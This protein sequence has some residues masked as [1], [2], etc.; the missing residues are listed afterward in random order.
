MNCKTCKWWSVKEDDQYDE[1]IRP[2][3][4]DYNPFTDEQIHLLYG[5]LVK[6]CHHPKLLFY[7]RPVKDGFA[8]CDGSK[9]RGTLITSEEFGCILHEQEETAVSDTD[10][11]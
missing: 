1:L 6:R 4:D 11:T 9:Y 7:E 2:L 3:D 5:H 8:V 10:K